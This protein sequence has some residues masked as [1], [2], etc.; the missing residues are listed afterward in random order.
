M[1]IQHEVA[2][3][4]AHDLARLLVLTLPLAL[5]NLRTVVSRSFLT[6]IAG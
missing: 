5:K 3:L 4:L 2:L 6:T 1:T